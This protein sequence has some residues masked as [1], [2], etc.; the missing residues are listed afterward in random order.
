MKTNSVKML[1]IPVAVA[2]VLSLS[3]AGCYEKDEKPAKEDA[4]KEHPA[5]EHP[6]KEHPAKD[7][8]AKEHPSKDAGSESK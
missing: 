3:L 7:D 6:A 1:I 8:A 4:A 2:A 5:K